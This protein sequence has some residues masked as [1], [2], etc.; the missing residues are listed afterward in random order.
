MMTEKDVVMNTAQRVIG[1]IDKFKELM[2]Q[3]WENFEENIFHQASELIAQ[4]V[5]NTFLAHL[6]AGA[7]P[8]AVQCSEWLARPLTGTRHQWQV[9]DLVSTTRC[10]LV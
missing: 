4:A 6:L 2:E 3:C 9:E 7:S 5:V 8:P 1:T 10:R